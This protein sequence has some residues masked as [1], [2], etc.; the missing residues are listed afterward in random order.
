M[1]KKREVGDELSTI[2]WWRRKETKKGRKEKRNKKE[3][4]ERKRFISVL[5]FF[6]RKDF[7]FLIFCSKSFCILFHDRFSLTL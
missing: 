7:P 4:G 5:F 1:R 6:I 3:G 2:C